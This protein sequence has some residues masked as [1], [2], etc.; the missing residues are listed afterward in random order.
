M[1]NKI[2][3]MLCSS[4]STKDATVHWTQVVGSKIHKVDLCEE[5]AK[6]KGLDDP[7][8]KALAGMLMGIGDEEVDEPALE[9]VS[10]EEAICPCCGFTQADFKKNLR[11]GCSECYDTFAGQ[12]R[13]MLKTMHRGEQHVGKIPKAFA[14]Q[15]NVANQLSELEARLEEAIKGEEFE[16]AARVRDEIRELR[17]Q[18][19]LEAG[20]S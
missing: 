5:C 17:A 14:I 3:S 9:E 7:A 18:A 2:P 20:E 13:G 12:L 8:G 11:F 4:C 19:Q 6:T 15:Q 10:S 1:K 16:E